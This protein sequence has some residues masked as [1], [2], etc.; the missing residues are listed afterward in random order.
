MAKQYDKK[1]PSIPIQQWLTSNLPRGVEAVWGENVTDCGEQTGTPE[2]D[3]GRDMP[4][5]AEIDLKKK[6]ELIGYLLLF[7]GTE[8]KGKMKEAGL[9]YG[10][11]KHGKKTIDLNEL[12][13]IKKMQGRM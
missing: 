5:C 3:K 9:Y 10:Y 12:R 7:V 11:F 13:D 8:K 4:L 1:L 2:I 6:G